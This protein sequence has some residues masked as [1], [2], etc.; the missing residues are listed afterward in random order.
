MGNLWKR[1]I[2]PICSASDN[3]LID[4]TCMSVTLAAMNE[5]RT[6]SRANLENSV[7]VVQRLLLQSTVSISKVTPQH[8]HR[9][10]ADRE[11]LRLAHVYTYRPS[12]NEKSIIKIFAR[13]KCRDW[14]NE[15][16]N[17]FQYS[18]INYTHVRIYLS[19]VC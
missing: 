12:G 4:P 11:K 5:S 2:E 8:T 3:P 1:V 9:G 13:L 14:D 18:F 17:I 16:S 7:A 10:L 19:A 15:I 6:K